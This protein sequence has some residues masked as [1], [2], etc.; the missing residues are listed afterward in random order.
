MR[1]HVRGTVDIPVGLL[2]DQEIAADERA[3]ACA[4]PARISAERQGDP[5]AYR[6]PATVSS[7]AVDGTT[8]RY[9]IAAPHVYRARLRGKAY[10][11]V[12]ERPAHDP[13][14]LEYRGTLVP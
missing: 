5:S 11:L 8:V 6:H 3:L 12:D 13:E 7:L 10:E 2:T 4:N 14:P 9:P 1:V